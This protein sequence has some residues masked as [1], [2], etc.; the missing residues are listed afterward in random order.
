MHPTLHQIL[1][2]PHSP[3]VLEMFQQ[4]RWHSEDRP[5]WPRTRR[6]KELFG[7]AEDQFADDF[8]SRFA[9]VTAS[10]L[11][12]DDG[13][14]YADIGENEVKMLPM[15]LLDC[16]DRAELDRFSQAAGERV[17]AVGDVNHNFLLLGSKGRFFISVPSCGDLRCLGEG[18]D[19]LV[20]YL[21]GGDY[22]TILNSK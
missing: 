19:G 5:G 17:V 7:G 2:G 22:T 12:G 3:A 16:I 8:L 15:M 20:N 9:D 11:I 13:D 18:W 1:H 10:Y 4:S 21:R 6:W 14:S